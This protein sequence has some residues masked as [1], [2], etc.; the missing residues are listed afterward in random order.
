MVGTAWA[1]FHINLI[2]EDDRDIAGL[3]QNAMD[4]SGFRTEV[5]SRGRLAVDRL[6]RACPIQYC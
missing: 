6:A 2:I 1:I 4:L 5:I 3:F